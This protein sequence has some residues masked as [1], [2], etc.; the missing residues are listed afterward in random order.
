MPFSEVGPAKPPGSS[1]SPFGTAH[2]FWVD[3]PLLRFVEE[4]VAFDPLQVGLFGAEGIVFEA[5]DVADLVK[6]FFVCGLVVH[7]Q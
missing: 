5:E 4:D 7:H 3:N 2:V 1:A 6:E